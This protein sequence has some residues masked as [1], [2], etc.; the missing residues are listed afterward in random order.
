MRLSAAGL[1]AY[2]ID[3]VELLERYGLVAEWVEEA[4]A[5][6]SRR[7]DGALVFEI[8]ATLPTR[9]AIGSAIEISELWFPSAGLLERSG[10]RYE[11]IDRERQHRRAFHRHDSAYFDRQFGVVVHEHCE[12]PIGQ[13]D[14]THFFGPPVRDGFRAVELL[15]AAWV[16]DPLDCR[17][18]PCLE[19]L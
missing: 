2:V 6:I 5:I 19:P 7:R 18:L 13:V 17:T 8:R 1:E 3:L 12:S 16:S 11:L 10:Y 15:M 14:C 4:A 9:A